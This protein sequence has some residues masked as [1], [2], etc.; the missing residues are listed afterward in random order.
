M[1]NLTTSEDITQLDLLKTA[2]A[3]RGSGTIRYAAAMY[4]YQHGEL[5][6]KALEIYR[7][8]AKDDNS[9]PRLALTTA[10]CEN[11]VAHLIRRKS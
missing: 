4:F 9:D 11:E 7:T 8:L 2:H 5:S 1:T 10:E 6:S 3:T